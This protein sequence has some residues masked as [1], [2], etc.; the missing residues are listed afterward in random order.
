MVG[1]V[2]DNYKIVS[3]LGEGG[4]GIVY[5]GFDIKL[6]RF[7]AIK[8]LDQQALKNSKFI[9]RFK[10][11]AK[12]QAKLN[13]PNIVPVYG[14]TEFN[15]LLGIIMEFVAGE[16][17]EHVIERKSNLE[18]AEAIGILK[19]ILLGVG[20]AH[21]KGYIHR[22]LKPSNIIIN[23]EGVAKIMDFG[24]SK[25][26]NDV[27][28]ITKTGTKLGT[29]LY[30]SPEQIKAQE[31]TIQSDIYSLGITFYEMLCG[32]TPF[33]APTD[34]HIMEA[35]LKKNPLKLTSILDNI[36]PDVDI[37]LN[38]ALS[39][40]VAKRYQTCEEFSVDLDSIPLTPF[41]SKKKTKRI[42]KQKFA[43]R[44]P[45]FRV[46]KFFRRLK[47]IALSILGLVVF[48][49]L[50]YFIY[51]QVSQL[52]ASSGQQVQ[53]LI[54]NGKDIYSS[55]PSYVN[56][57]NWKAVTCPVAADLYG[58]VFLNGRDGFACGTNSALIKTTD[59]GKSWKAIPVKV[60]NNTFYDIKFFN[61]LNGIITGSNGTLLLTTDGG[62]FWNRVDTGV[63]ETMF[64]IKIL[65]NSSIGFL[66]GGNGTILKTTD[67]GYS[68]KRVLSPSRNLLYDV[69]FSSNTVGFAV[70]WNAELLKS[71]DQGISWVKMNQAGDSYFRSICF[72]DSS[73][74]IIV[75][76]G[77]EILR[78]TDGGSNW[79]V[80]SSGTISGLYSVSFTDSKNA[81]ILGSKGEIL[82]T[83]DGG[84]KWKSTSSGKFVALTRMFVLPSKKMVVIGYN[85]TILL[86][87]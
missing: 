43:R 4:M 28:A 18:L 71:T 56:K 22:D 40:T 30:M 14:F 34:F 50:S 25:S 87:Q 59:G 73:L 47:T 41:K 9:E 3:I 11:E 2:I 15:G 62:N 61:E 12:N 8:I 60:A 26:L 21:S 49:A 31:P 46:K 16:T 85:G 86:S 54:D 58:L 38:K 75:G 53:K 78:T 84:S 23:Y 39:K 45:K 35:H 80:I 33:E 20:F 37:V 48:A 57:S 69:D 64:A 65:P 42:T 51:Q 10:R 36:P 19:Q 63:N 52:L 70:G 7:V 68:W 32:K 77:G 74:G 67:S 27:K 24:I 82:V 5:K 29:V 13:H 66:V 55:N 83:D 6:E 17:L 44:K 1:S 81:F 79:N 72:A 76:G